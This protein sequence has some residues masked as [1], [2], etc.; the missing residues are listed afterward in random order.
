M[1]EKKILA[2]LLASRE[3]YDKVHDYLDANDF[4]AES[5]LILRYVSEFYGTDGG[6]ERVDMDVLLGRLQRAI[7]SPK[8]F[9]A[10]KNVVTN[11][12][13]VSAP[14]ITKELLELKRYAT[15]L[16]LSQALAGNRGDAVSKYLETYNRLFALTELDVS[17]EIEA[18][19]LDLRSLVSG[20]FTGEN[21]IKLR[22]KALN[23]RLD[24][25]AK[26]GHHILLFAQ[27]EM[28]KTL[29]AI[30]MV[31]GF[32]A[33]NHKVMY[34][35]NEDPAADIMMRL[36]S[37]LSGM[38][39]H[40]I[41][42][43]P[44][45]A[46]QR[47][48]QA[49]VENFTMVEASPGTFYRI[50]KLADKYNPKI[51]LLDQLRN[52]DVKA[53]GRTNQLEKA[54]TEARNLAKSHGV[55]VVSITQAADSAS[56]KRVLNRGDVDSSNVGIPGQVDVMVGIGA[57][58]EEEAGGFRT[59]SLPKNKLGGDHTHFPVQFEPKFSRI[60]EAQ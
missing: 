9:E 29:F 54:A 30:N 14:N 19:G 56:G 1:N 22:P 27:T 31:A 47:C 15:G 25:G 26:P 46:T 44:E 34:V 49:G 4:S 42:Q 20:H 36:G 23:T 2:V 43:N 58:E 40:Q 45:L 51:I 41:I 37:C 48:E 50:R 32:L 60:Q 13:V 17:K 11:L 21:L 18:C 7:P 55:L 52:I 10:I 35:G 6:T 3:A 38:D 28:G 33:D 12:P 59:I 24:G 39:K 8:Q 57:S 5:N 53:D 16:K